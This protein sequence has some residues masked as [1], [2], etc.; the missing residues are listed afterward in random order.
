MQRYVKHGY[1]QQ[2]C[3]VIV[4][5]LDS[6]W[7]QSTITHAFAGRSVYTICTCVYNV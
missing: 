5:I 7:W 6:N 1:F 3:Y 2:F 4:Y